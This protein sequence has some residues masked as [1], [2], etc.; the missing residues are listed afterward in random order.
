MI[1]VI[2]MCKLL[3]ITFIYFLKDSYIFILTRELKKL[4]FN[5]ENMQKTLIFQILFISS[6]LFNLIRDKCNVQDPS[7]FA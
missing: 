5:A 3:I 2:R 1:P 4:S 6:V 7:D